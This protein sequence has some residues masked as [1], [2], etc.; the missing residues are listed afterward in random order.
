MAQTIGS[1]LV[2]QGST[3]TSNLKKSLRT[4]AAVVISAGLVGTFALPAYATTE[5]AEG[6]PDG[7]Y[8]LQAQTL[9]TEFANEELDTS[10]LVAKVD[11]EAI[12]REQREAAEAE[13]QRVQEQLAEAQRQQQEASST[14]SSQAAQKD[15]PAGAGSSGILNA[16]LAQLGQGQDC[17][18]LVER[19]LRAAGYGAGDL[20]TSIGEYAQYG[21]VVGDGSLAPGDILIWP[22]QHVAVYMGNGQAVH[23]GWQGNQTVVATAYV[24]GPPTAVRVG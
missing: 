21:A 5:S 24:N 11:Q 16:A 3:K 6:M 15:L 10:A 2:A 7:L 8:S 22:G 19:A 9:T 18:A 20:G 23:G 4:A 13:A 12:E 17:T 1:E 14:A